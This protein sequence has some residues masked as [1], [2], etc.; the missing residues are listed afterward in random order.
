MS[1]SSE[2]A[3]VGATTQELGG[4]QAYS[5]DLGV[6]AVQRTRFIRLQLYRPYGA[7]KKMGDWGAT[8]MSPLR[9]LGVSK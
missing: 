1:K 6:P 8:N 7:W 5:I 3:Y 4:C 9:G 2:D